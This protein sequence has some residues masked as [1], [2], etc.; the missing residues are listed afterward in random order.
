MRIGSRRYWLGCLAVVALAGGGCGGTGPPI[1]QVTGTITFD[2][3][4]VPD[5]DIVFIPE[6]AQYGAEAGKIKEGKYRLRA[7]DG[8]NKVQ[9]RA[10]RPVPGKVGPMGEPAIEDYIPAKYN[11]RTT[12]FREVGERHTEF[13]FELKSNK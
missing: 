1:H 9:I 2:D 7:H 5:G 11:D 10:T 4:P 13:N 6:D 12:L 3:T 8:K